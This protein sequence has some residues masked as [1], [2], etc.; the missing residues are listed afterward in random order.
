MPHPMVIQ[1][2]FTRNEFR[3]ALEGV[4]DADAQKRFMPMNCIS[5]S[6]GHLAWQE[7]RYW[8]HYGQGQ[9]PLPEIQTHAYG[10]P[11]STPSL[12]SVW[13]AWETII[14]TADPWLDQFT[15]EK[16]QDRVVI[17]GNTTQYIYGSLLQ[18]VIYHYWY[19]TGINMAI[20]KLLGHTGLPDFVGDI[21]GEAPYRPED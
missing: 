11:A 1:L 21:D 14:N 10:A 5:W 12:S 16:L 3:R 13:N 4:S 2:R 17:R 20:R 6:I 19:H 8:L 15:T 7:Q 9:M 18:R